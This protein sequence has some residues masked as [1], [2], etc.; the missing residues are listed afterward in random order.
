M[1]WSL[2]QHEQGRQ[3]NAKS[4][5][6][7]ERRQLNRW[8]AADCATGA[9]PWAEKMSSESVALPSFP[10]WQL[11]WAFRLGARRAGTEVVSRQ[12]D[13]IDQSRF[14]AREANDYKAKGFSRQRVLY[15]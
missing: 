14:V 11:F 5:R 4:A 7:P 6:Q 8:S 3:P 10:D 15:L 9:G 1:I 12:T 13:A 2:P